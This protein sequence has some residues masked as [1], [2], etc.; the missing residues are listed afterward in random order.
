MNIASALTRSAFRRFP[1]GKRSMPYRIS[2]KLMLVVN[3]SIAICVDNQRETL[4]FGEEDIASEITFVSRTIMHSLN[5][6]LWNGFT[7]RDS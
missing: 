1:G 2:A 4:P 3:S 5:S 6:G 7:W